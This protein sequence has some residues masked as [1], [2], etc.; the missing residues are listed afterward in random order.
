VIVGFRYSRPRFFLERVLRTVLRND[1]G[2]SSHQHVSWIVLIMNHRVIR[3]YLFL[4]GLYLSDFAVHSDRV[5]PVNVRRHIFTV[6]L[7]CVLSCTF[8]I[9]VLFI[10][11]LLY[12]IH[13]AFNTHVSSY[14]RDRI[15]HP[16]IRFN[17]FGIWL[18]QFKYYSKWC[19]LT[20]MCV[21]ILT[22]IHYL[23]LCY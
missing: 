4:L 18:I 23:Y 17:Y 8:I 16:V 21:G 11:W 10:L 9:I 15:N 3:F 19:S 5:S 7:G 13:L 12:F 1:G 22:P 14:V 20:S 2:A 6:I